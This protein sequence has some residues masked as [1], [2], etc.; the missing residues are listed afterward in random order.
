MALPS[1]SDYMSSRYLLT[2]SKDREE[3]ERAIGAC[4]SNGGIMKIQERTSYTFSLSLSLPHRMLEA[5]YPSFPTEGALLQALLSDATIG[6]HIAN[7][8]HFLGQFALLRRQLEI[9]GDLLPNLVEFYQWLHQELSHVVTRN[10]AETI[11][12][13]RAVRVLAKSYSPEEGDRLHTLFKKMK[14]L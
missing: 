2:S 3:R 10:D 14:G 9:G 12:L 6:D 4:R 7:H 5:Q 8:Q 13:S 1:T 11:P